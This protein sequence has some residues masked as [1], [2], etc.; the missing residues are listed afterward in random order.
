MKRLLSAVAAATLLLGVSSSPA[1]AEAQ[2]RNDS[3]S[4]DQAAGEGLTSLAL[5]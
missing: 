3:G 2:V 4:A 5:P 1:A